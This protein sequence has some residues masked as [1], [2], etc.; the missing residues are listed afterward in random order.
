MKTLLAAIAF[1]LVSNFCFSQVDTTFLDKDWN[2][3]TR[4]KAA[5]YRFVKKDGAKLFVRDFYINN[6]PQSEAVCTSLEPYVRNGKWIEYRED[7]TKNSEG[8]FIDEKPVGKWTWWNEGEKDSTIGE[9]KKDGTIYILNK[10][11]YVTLRGKKQFVIVEG[12]GQPTVVFVTGKGDAQYNYGPVYREIK[13]QTQIF[14]YDRAGLGNSEL[15][16]NARRVD[17]MAYELNELLTKEN[18]KPPYVLVGHS[19]GGWVIRCFANMYP[20]KVAGLIFIDAACEVELKKGLEVRADSDKVKFKNHYKA[21]LNVP[22]RSKGNNAESDYC[23]NFDETNY[24]TDEKI[25]KDLKLPS[26]IPITVFLSTKPKENDPYY[27]KQD[28]DIRINFFESWKKQAPQLKLITT[29]NSGHY[30]Y[31]EEPNL[32]IDGIKDMLKELKGK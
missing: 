27:L 32:I 30:I 25:V 22:T 13:K 10:G 21:Y 29:P 19:L 20:K 7:G 15:I 12:K 9:Y 26:N 24:S 17:T 31:V 1:F 6:K 11:H 14:S 23:F 4:S 28:L 18:I 8:Q 5:Y 2:M 3:C 16:E